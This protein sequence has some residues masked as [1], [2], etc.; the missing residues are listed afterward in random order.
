MIEEGI[1]KGVGQEG[2]KNVFQL[3]WSIASTLGKNKIEDARVKKALGEYID[4]YLK[5][6]GFI[7]VLGMIEPI[8]L[9][10]IYTSVRVIHP[11]YLHKEKAIE[12]LEQTFRGNRGD[13]GASNDRFTGIEVANKVKLLNLLGPPGSGK[14][15]FLKKIGLEALKSNGIQSGKVARSEEYSHNCLPVLIE[16][17][18]FRD[19]K[20]DLLE[21][22]IEEFAIAGFPES[23]RFVKKLLK[24]GNL[25]ILLDGLDEVPLEYLESAIQHIRDFASK[26]GKNRFITSCRTAFYKNYLKDFTDVEITSFDNQQVQKFIKNWFRLERDKVADT[27]ETFIKLL[28]NRKNTAS[29][30]LARTPLLLTFLCL[31]FDDTQRFPANRTALY[32]NAL[33][34][35]LQRWAAE[36]RVHNED[37]YKDLHPDLEIEMLA[38][39]AASFF[40]KDKIFFFAEEIKDA[41]KVFMDSLH[42]SR[43]IDI[44]KILAAIEVQQGLL[45]QRAP[46]IFSFSHLTIQ[47]YLASYFYYSTRKTNNLIENYL[48]NRRWREVF[49]L[50][51]GFSNADDFIT[52]ISKHVV[53]KYEKDDI[54][55]CS[56]NWANSIIPVTEDFEA[57]ACKRAF[58][59]SLLLRYKRYDGDYPNKEIR[60]ESY[61]EELL[62]SLN[63]SFAKSFRLKP[64]LNKA[65]AVKLLDVIANWQGDHIRYISFQSKLNTLTPDAPWK[66]ML[67]GSKHRFR[68][69]I[70]NVFYDALNVP[71][72]VGELRKNE[73]D[74]LIKYYE[75]LNLLSDCKNSA[76]RLSKE[77]W[78]TVC[79]NIFKSYKPTVAI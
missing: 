16:L 59:V 28:F 75:D 78:K 13:F 22:I 54:V 70:V 63:Q 8:P 62:I 66:K 58:V 61:S 15:T 51:A 79:L 6:H 40:E 29:L 56:I 69:K 23:I 2:A 77:T 49:L 17:R 53:K 32:K 1:E 33:L 60:L 67:M 41:I 20:I 3:V 9:L 76:L 5:R 25:L 37:I 36:K 34:I 14:S 18:K 42:H 65:G 57:D 12:E 10:D 48:G 72:D 44:S 26:F 27:D 35:L 52:A 19:G 30:E 47:E 21:R 7:K 46:Q 45:V 31:T 73:Y 24:S 68:R 11:K 38:E 71:G 50:L 39:I 74:S 4:R 55:Q 43:F 64:N